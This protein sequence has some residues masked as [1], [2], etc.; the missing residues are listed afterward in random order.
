M[1]G[2]LRK[3]LEI[4][5]SVQTLSNSYIAS[6]IKE[7]QPDVRSRQ[8]LSAIIEEPMSCE[9]NK[10]FAKNQKVVEKNVTFPTKERKESL[11]KM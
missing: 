10:D 5:K 6:E 2:K 8:N 7:K 9:N 11:D 1:E 3:T 4:M